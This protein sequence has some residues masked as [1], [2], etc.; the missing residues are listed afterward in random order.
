MK[1][2]YFVLWKDAAGGVYLEYFDSQKKFEANA[3]RPFNKKKPP[4]AVHECFSINKRIVAIKGAYAIAI[5]TADD[6]FTIV[7]DSDKEQREWLDTLVQHWRQ[8]TPLNHSHAATEHVWQVKLLD[9]GLSEKQQHLAG[10]HRLCLTPNAL[11][12]YKVDPDDP[13]PQPIEMQLKSIRKCGHSETYFTVELGRSSSIGEQQLLMQVEDNALANHMHKA[14]HEAM[15]C[16][17]AREEFGP[18]S[19]PRSASTSDSGKALSSRRS[20]LGSLAP[21]HTFSSSL[22]SAGTPSTSSTLISVQHN[23]AAV[24]GSSQRDRSYSMHDRSRPHHAA[25]S[26]HTDNYYNLDFGARSTSVDHDLVAATP[27]AAAAE[28]AAYVQTTIE[29]LKPAGSELSGRTRVPSA[30]HDTWPGAHGERL[31]EEEDDEYIAMSPGSGENESSGSRR[32]SFLDRSINY[33]DNDSSYMEM[34][35]EADGAG[36]EGYLDMTPLSSS[37]PKGSLALLSS[38]PRTA[39]AGG[40]NS[41]IYTMPYF[42]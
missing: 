9:K 26:S 30:R 34:R 42:S 16:S 40:P 2:R 4:I 35:P 1:T 15:K 22:A 20:T 31:V 37:L 12:L 19:R 5:Y 41:P 23:S 36:E 3:N 6:V 10:R 27:L 13:A 14:I 32:S 33:D 18:M 11:L 8:R 17:T 24:A 39:G 21:G 7:F 29:P 25:S 38:S 28:E